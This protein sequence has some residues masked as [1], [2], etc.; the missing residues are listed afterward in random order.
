[1]GTNG[2]HKQK[3]GEGA[4]GK[5]M[6]RGADELANAIHADSNIGERGSVFGHGGSYSPSE[7]ADDQRIVDRDFDG[8]PHN[9]SVIDERLR[10][11]ERARD[12]RDDRDASREMELER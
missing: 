7:V 8:E 1:M 3:I 4:F 6:A 10:Q 2:E 5:W 12:D 9:D 11:A